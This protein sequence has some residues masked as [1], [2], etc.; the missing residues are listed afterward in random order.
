V[1]AVFESEVKSGFGPGSAVRR[2]HEEG[3]LLLG[4]GRALLMQIAQPRVAHG[5]A[6]HSSFRQARLQRLLRTLRPMLAIAYGTPGQ[7]SEA[8]SSIN[9]THEAIQGLDY[10]ARDPELLLWVLATLID[11]TLVMQRLFVRPLPDHEAEAYYRD[12]Q[13]IG[14]ALGLPRAL[15][16]ADLQAFEAYMRTQIES[17]RVSDEARAIADDLF[18]YWPPQWAAIWPLRQLT[19]GLLPPELREQ[20]GMSWGPGRQRTLDVTTSATRRLLPLVPHRLRRTP[21]F[22]MPTR[23]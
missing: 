15:M 9:R 2:V 19:A 12:M 23:A 1:T 10:D 7:A 13:L 14:E 5:V 17:L 22:L 3:V 4:G 11:T 20:F 6:Q 8:A 16:P 21:D 18:R